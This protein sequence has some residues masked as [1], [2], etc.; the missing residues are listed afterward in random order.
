M[1]DKTVR[2]EET[3]DRQDDEYLELKKDRTFNYESFS[4]RY[5][6]NDISVDYYSFFGTGT[7]LVIK[8]SLILNFSPQ[9]KIGLSQKPKISPRFI[10]PRYKIEDQL[11]TGSRALIIIIRGDSV[12]IGNLIKADNVN[13]K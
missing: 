9:N 2:Y 13:K 1:H 7:Y 6:G 11:L 12:K 10:R 4:S 5:L 8:D 3:A